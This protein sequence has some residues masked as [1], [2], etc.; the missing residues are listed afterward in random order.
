MDRLAGDDLQTLLNVHDGWCVSLY[1]PLSRKGAEASGNPTR[2]KN[3]LRLAQE[4]LQERGLREDKA[5][6]YLQPAWEFLAEHNW[7]EHDADGLALFLHEQELWT[8]HLPLAFEETAKVAPRFHLRPLWP[9]FTHDGRFYILALSQKQVRLLLGTRQSVSELS[10]NGIPQSLEEI[11][12]LYTVEE[13][14]Q[15]H[16]GARGGKGKESGVFHGGHGV[17]AEVKEDQ[18]RELFRLVDQGVREALHE[19]QPAP[20]LVAGVES[21]VGHYRHANTYSH[22]AEE[23]LLGNPDLLSNEELH[24]RAWELLAPRFEASLRQALEQWDLAT[25]REQTRHHLDEALTAAAGGQIAALFVPLNSEIWGAYDPDTA[26]VTLHEDP[27]PGDADLLDLL[28]VQT[29]ANRGEVWALPAEELPARPVAA[30]L[31]Y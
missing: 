25:S 23:A 10:L 2:F 1:L 17:G 6:A 5:R 28:V 24:R 8:Y 12:R 3:L 29:L 27:Q 13:Q 18:L 14:L 4:R 22:L 9:L 19:P 20:L 16:S 7:R 15:S 26:A 31:R 21:V 30:I 11:Q